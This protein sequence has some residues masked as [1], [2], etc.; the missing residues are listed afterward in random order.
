[1]LTGA[2]EMVVGR[3]AAK[4]I[5]WVGSG[6]DAKVN[7]GVGS[8]VTGKVTAGVGSGVA[9]DVA[10]LP[11]T[12]AIPVLSS[13]SWKM[14]WSAGG[15]GGEVASV[16]A[17]IS[18]LVV[19]G[20]GSGREIPCNSSLISCILREFLYHRSKVCSLRLTSIRLVP[21][22]MM[23][24]FRTLAC[25]ELYADSTS[26]CRDVNLAFPRS[27]NSRLACVILAY[28]WIRM[29]STIRLFDGEQA[30][31]PPDRKHLCE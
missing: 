16:R 2:V 18:G 25:T 19:Q 24:L 8:R 4:E 10:S 13:T 27:S 15:S 3:V 12:L 26:L 5:S 29:T 30:G 14:C 22:M 28:K 1:M 11:L 20:C 6:V 23:L 9:D 7:T 17:G 31:T 21:C